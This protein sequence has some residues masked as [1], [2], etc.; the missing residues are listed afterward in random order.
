M[1]LLQLHLIDQSQNIELYIANSG[2]NNLSSN[3]KST[4]GLWKALTIFEVNFYPE[5]SNLLSAD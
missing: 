2:V 3:V 4:D 5:N 1:S